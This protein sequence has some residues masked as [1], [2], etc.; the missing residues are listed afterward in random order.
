MPAAYEGRYHQQCLF[1]YKCQSNH[2]NGEF[3]NPRLS[4]AIAVIVGLSFF[5]GCA[6]WHAYSH[7]VGDAELSQLNS[8]YVIHNKDDTGGLDKVVLGAFGKMGFDASTGDRNNI[9][10]DVDAIVTY[11]FHWFWDITNYLLMLKVLIRDAETMWPLAMGESVRT[12]LAR[13]PPDD[14]AIEILAPLFNPAVLQESK[15]KQ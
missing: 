8:F 15:A 9:P 14:M 10:N 3:M 1:F 11:E 4:R 12:S 7:K 13:K 5:A 2:E 6:P